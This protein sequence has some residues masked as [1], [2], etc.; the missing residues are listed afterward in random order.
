MA[1]S[2]NMD[3]SVFL[4]PDN[5]PLIILSDDEASGEM[6]M[7]FE[8]TQNNVPIKQ[9][10]IDKRNSKRKRTEDQELNYK[11]I[12]IE[13]CGENE[14]TLKLNTRTKVIKSEDSSSSKIEKN[15][16]KIKKELSGIKKEKLNIK[17][18][19]Y[20]IIYYVSTFH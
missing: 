5:H 19:S 2:D 17:K 3:D 9:E 16:S 20:V 1:E 6:V 7:K 14:S 18:E 12:K 11:K 10:L 8:V 15:N 13:K 4:V